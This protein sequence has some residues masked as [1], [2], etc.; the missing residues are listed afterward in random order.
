MLK[1]LGF[2]GFVFCSGSV[3]DIMELLK[4]SSADLGLKVS[5]HFSHQ[6]VQVCFFLHFP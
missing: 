2:L 4:T 1:E 6:L 3:S 5:A